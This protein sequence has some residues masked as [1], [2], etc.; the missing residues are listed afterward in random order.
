[1]SVTQPISVPGTTQNTEPASEQVSD[2][3]DEAVSQI[4]SVPAETPTE[5]I[6]SVTEK[7]DSKM[8][9]SSDPN[10]IFISAV[11]KKYSVNASNL[12]AYYLASEDTN[13]NLVYE[14]DGTIGSDG[15]PVRTIETLKNIYA[16][17]APPELTAKKASG[18]AAEGNEYNERDTRLCRYF[19]EFVVFRFFS[20][21]LQNA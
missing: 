3:T 13:G 21:E 11:V 16:V 19:T 2:A 9:F 4:T 17:S 12:V 5:Q 6:T 1:M 20:E 14:F 10:N 15:R 18:T 8:V 7:S